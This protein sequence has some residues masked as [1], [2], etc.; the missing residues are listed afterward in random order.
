MKSK[1]DPWAAFGKFTGITLGFAALLAVSALVRGL[2]LV[3]LWKW[4]VVP[5]GVSTV[6]LT[7]A[8]GLSILVG[9]LWQHYTPETE[10]QRRRST[11]EKL[12]E[13]FFASVFMAFF[14]LAFGWIVQGIS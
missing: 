1:S 6:H 7:Q 13:G 10:E 14:A 8:I 5:L 3:Q 2:V 12:F 4:Y 11:A 9:M